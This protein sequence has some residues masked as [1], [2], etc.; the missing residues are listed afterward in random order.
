MSS[1]PAPQPVSALHA[2][3]SLRPDLDVVE[4]DASDGSPAVLVHDPVAETFDRVEWPESDLIRLLRHPITVPQ[5]RDA[6]MRRNPMQPTMADL[7]AYLVE[8][9][10][11]GWLRDSR[12]W[13]GKKNDRPGAGLIGL[14]GRLLFV[15]IPLVR[16]EHFLQATRWVAAL[17]INPFSIG[18]FI[19]CGLAGA[20]L[21]LPRWE[22]FWRDSLGS[23]ALARL[24]GF[25]A[26]LALVKLAHELAHAYVATRNG[27]RVKSMG[28]ALFFFMPLPFTDVTDAWRLPWKA[29]LRVAAAGMLAELSLAGVALLLWALSPPGA[30]A[31]LLARLA[32]LAILSTLLTNLNPGPRFDGYYMLVCLLRIENL[33]ARGGAAL[34]RLV[35]KSLFGISVPDPEERLRRGQK[36]GML[37]YAVYA[38]GY[39]FSLG[40]GLA[41][42]A[43]YMFPKVLGLPIAAMELWLFFGQPV[44]AEVILLWRGREKMRF[45]VGLLLF[46]AV[47]GGLAIWVFGEWPRRLHFPAVTRAA[48][49]EA[50]RSRREGTLTQVSARRGDAVETGQ[51]LAVLASPLDDPMLRSAEWALREAEIREE[52]SWAGSAARQE[53]SSRAAERK[54]R[55]VQLDA[56]R[57][58]NDL[59]TV[60]APAPGELLVWDES[61]EP[62]LPVGRG[63]LLGWIAGGRVD[64]LSCYPDIETASR[65]EPGAEVKF[66]PDTGDGFIR[67]RV[68]RIDSSRPEVLEDEA[69][70]LQLG[71]VLRNGTYVLGRPYAKVTVALE[72]GA[73]RTGQTGR[74]WLWSKPESL[75]DRAYLWLRGLAVRESSF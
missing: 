55:E 21:T 69:L 74:V 43:Y 16:P 17:V 44:V 30:M 5:L 31:M 57:Q 68:V 8:I 10:Q 14:F 62:G 59:L 23:V 15:Q 71:A 1:V 33:R 47:L 75:A 73:G 60:I 6:F 40:I 4:V 41:L 70:A 13:P 42:L 37:V 38:I 65:I 25:I 12:F 54:S 48:R 26:A 63:R 50:V 56:L 35:H 46:L 27:A 36:T 39:R 19:L 34:R 49:E 18:L 51:V 28:M 45:T 22:D 32:S 3:W 20:Y 29:R 2:V 67:G 64:I 66:F 61:V 58:R 7:A 9:G 11:R 52:Q 53:S 72:E 24:P